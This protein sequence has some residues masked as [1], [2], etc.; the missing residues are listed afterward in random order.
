MQKLIHLFSEA[1]H[2]IEWVDSGDKSEG[3]DHEA[4]DA[5]L[6]FM[7]A[8]PEILKKASAYDSLVDFMEH[9]RKGTPY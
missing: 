4:I 7:G 1:M 3:G 6:S 2:D 5:C 9:N 8:D